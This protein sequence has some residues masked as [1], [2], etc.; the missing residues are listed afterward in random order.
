MRITI[1]AAMLAVSVSAAAQDG[2]WE[3]PQGEIWKN[4][5]GECWR[6]GLW[7]KD[8]II[9]GCDGMTAAKAAPAPKPVAAAPA[10]APAAAPAPVAPPPAPK[11]TDGDGV[12]D[13]KD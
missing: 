10:P 1:A 4:S 3:N 6:T 12:T 5:Y 11:D 13:D 8:K 2:Y 9:V 7:S